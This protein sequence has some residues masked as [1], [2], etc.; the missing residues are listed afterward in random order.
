[1]TF[2]MNVYF[3]KLFKYSLLNNLSCHI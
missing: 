3:T 1:V 2:G